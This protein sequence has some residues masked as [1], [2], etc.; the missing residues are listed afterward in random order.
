MRYTAV[1]FHSTCFLIR[2]TA[3]TPYPCRQALNDWPDDELAR[4]RLVLQK[5][6]C[7]RVLNPAD[8]EDLVQETLLTMVVRCPGVTIEKGLLIWGLGILRNKVGN[9]YRNTRRNPA[10]R[11]N[12]SL[13][14]IEGE[15][16]NL[17][18]PESSLHYAELCSLVEDILKDFSPRERRPVE[19]LLAGSA[20]SEIAECLR[21]ERYQ[22]VVNRLHRGRRKLALRLATFGYADR[23][24]RHRRT[25]R[26][27]RRQQGRSASRHV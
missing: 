3:A 17:D 12:A 21:P 6:T 10:S 22:N 14:E 2:E 1:F 23:L 25:S 9:Y 26:S 20:T 4:I 19:M 7:L 15:Y 5:L 11:W 24:A 18:S 16:V 27:L 8:A 13:Q